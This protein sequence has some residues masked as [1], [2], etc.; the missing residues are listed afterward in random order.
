MKRKAI[1]DCLGKEQYNSEKE[2]AGDAL[3]IKFERKISLR[4]YKCGICEKFHL[5]KNFSAAS[6]PD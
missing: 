2:A 5:A 6:L 4:V 3:R 1:N